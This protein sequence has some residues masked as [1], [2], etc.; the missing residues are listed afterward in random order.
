[1]EPV[2]VTID[3]P[4]P[5]D[6]V[7]D[8]LDVMAN[9]EP[10][11]DHILKDWE[12]SG[13]DR[14]VGSRARVHVTAAGRTE[15]VDIEVVDAERPTRI[16]ERNVG[17]GGKRVANGTYTLSALPAGGTHVQ[18][19]YAWRQAPLSERVMSPL[20]RGMLRRANQ[21]AMV[22]LAERLQNAGV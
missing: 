21:R 16:V 18:F 4:Q 7:F 2:H 22:R 14:G 15:T 5:I 11:T 19:E 1:M 12:Y 8:F 10:F 3:V 9:H 17:A 13:P 6:E 20:V